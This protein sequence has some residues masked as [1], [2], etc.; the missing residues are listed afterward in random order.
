VGYFQGPFD[1]EA[2]P[3]RSHRQLAD[4]VTSQFQRALAA[5]V[6]LSIGGEGWETTH[7][8]K[9]TQEDLGGLDALKATEAL[10]PPPPVDAERAS[11]SGFEM[12][13]RL[14]P[15]FQSDRTAQF[16]LSHPLAGHSAMVRRQPIS[17]PRE[18]I[19]IERQQL[20]LPRHT[21][22]DCWITN[23]VC[24][25]PKHEALPPELCR[26]SWKGIFDLRS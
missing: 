7:L 16:G 9:N 12:D 10:T 13:R 23:K 19:N 1:A 8:L 25:N 24:F 22:W 2:I 20:R 17:R 18:M 11:P 3:K 6:G 15:A 5:Y 4:V 14:P 26:P 21:I